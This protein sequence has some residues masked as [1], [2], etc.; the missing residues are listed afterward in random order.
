MTEQ[1]L[2]LPWSTVKRC[3]QQQGMPFVLHATRAPGRDAQGADVRVVRALQRAEHLE[4][5]V[6]AFK[7]EVESV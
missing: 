5:T 3:L 7:T 4:I 2:G 6:C 1:Y